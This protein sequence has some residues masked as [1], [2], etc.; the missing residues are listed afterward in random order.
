[1]L[2]NIP[3][4]KHSVTRI[5]VIVQGVYYLFTSHSA[6]PTAQHPGTPLYCKVYRFEQD[7][8]YST[9]LA[10]AEPIETPVTFSKCSGPQ[11]CIAASR[12]KGTGDIRRREFFHDCLTAMVATD[13]PTP[14]CVKHPHNFT[15]SFSYSCCA[16]YRCHLEYP[17]FKA[18][19][20]DGSEI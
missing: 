8:D 10:A 19:Y 6:E 14:D 2:I 9:D 13:Y 15:S 4:R 20:D 16:M 18:P 5:T 11:T 12:I 1:M 7:W 3:K 17:I